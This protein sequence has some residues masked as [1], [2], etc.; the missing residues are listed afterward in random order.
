M[1]SSRVELLAYIGQSTGHDV[2]A[3]RITVDVHAIID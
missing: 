3:E 2:L 1:D